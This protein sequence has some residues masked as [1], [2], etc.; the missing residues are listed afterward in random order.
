MT[1]MLLLSVVLGL[2]VGPLADRCGYRLLIVIGL[3][4]AAL[5]LLA[6]GLAPTFPVLLLASVAGSVT[7]AAVLGPTLA[8]VGTAFTGTAARRAIGWTSAAQAGSA[9][10]GVPIL[11]GIGAAAGWRVAFVVAGLLA[12]VAVG[13]ALTWIPH[14]HHQTAGSLRLDALVVPYR[15][16]LQSGTMRCLYGAIMFGA[17]CWYGLLTYLGA[18]L[19]EALG[20]RIGH[21]GLVYMVAGSGFFLGSLAVGGPLAQVPARTLVVG[22]YAGMALL[23]AVAFSARLGATGS[24]V[25]I[26]VA[27]LIMGLGVVSMTV[28]LT[29]ESPSSPGTTMTLSGA[30]FNLGGAGGGALGGLLLALSGFEAVAIGLPLFGLLAA[31]LSW[32]SARAPSHRLADTDMRT[33]N[34]AGTAQR[35]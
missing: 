12:V 32:R 9:I 11:V 7:N 10:V 1:A 14:D 27:A 2:V 15:P 18:F 30:L 33:G 22:G 17:V 8:I 23:M 16:L 31:L 13:L 25:L 5:C 29:T 20:M 34:D 26:A 28:L 19:A 35:T 3:V 4:A 6:F 21:V 24:A